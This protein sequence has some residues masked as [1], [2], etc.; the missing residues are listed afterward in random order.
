MTGAPAP[1]RA[2]PAARPGQ[3]LLEPRRV[4]RLEQVI[5]GV[6]LERLDGV[7]VEG[8]DEHQRRR[9]LL[10]A[11]E[12]APGHLE[13]AQPGHLDVEEDQVRLVTVDGGQRLDAVARLRHD[14]HVAELL[15]LVAQLVARELLVVTTMHAKRASCGDLFARP[16]ARE[17]RCARACPRPARWSA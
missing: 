5:D 12:Q 4:H 8:G 2:Q 14:F 16:A 7:L 10:L 13:P 1:V 9:L 3:R 11:F 17:S 15:E 6:D